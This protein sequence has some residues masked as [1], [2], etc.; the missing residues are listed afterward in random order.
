MGSPL[1]QRMVE[2]GWWPEAMAPWFGD[3]ENYGNFTEGKRS[4]SQFVVSRERIKSLP[5]EFYWNMYV[6]L[7]TNTKGEVTTG[8]DPVL[9]CR[10]ITEAD[11]DSNSNYFTS[12]YM[13]WSWE[14]IFTCH[15]PHEDI[16]EP[17]LI[18]EN[19]KKSFG[20]ISALYGANKYFRDVTREVIYH[21]LRNEK[22]IIPVGANFNDL[23]TDVIYGDVK[24][25]ILNING[26]TYNI[27][28]I[29]SEDKIINLK[30]QLQN[31]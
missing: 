18:T 7:V 28:E 13:E 23:F 11:N 24:T 21:F 17:F 6:W 20:L 31:S 22:I 14:F 4:C 15:K 8:F 5:R 26:K 16:A 27:P 3:I 2:S 12:R 19:G 30:G 29:R 9:K 1:I 10:Y 25:L